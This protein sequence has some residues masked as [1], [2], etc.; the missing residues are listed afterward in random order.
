MGKN[1]GKNLSENF[2]DVVTTK[3]YNSNRITSTA[4]QSNLDTASK[5]NVNSLEIPKK[6]YIPGKKQQIIDERRSI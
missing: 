5:T 6:R 1:V 2:S 3:S 4:S